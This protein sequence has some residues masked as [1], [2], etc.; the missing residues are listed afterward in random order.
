MTDTLAPTLPASPPSGPSAV[1]P[2]LR[3][4]EDL[5]HEAPLEVGELLGRGGMGEVRACVDARLGRELALKASTALDAPAQARF[6]REARIQGQ[7]E[8]PGMVPVHELGLDAKG[9]PYFTMKRV[10]GVTLA[11][12]L[13]RLAQGEAATVARFP[14][15]KLLAAVVSVAQTVDFAHTRGVMHRDVKPANVML[16]DFGEVYLLDWGLAKV[17]HQPVDSE[18]ITANGEVAAGA[19]LAG[20]VMG[21]PGYMAPEQARGQEATPASDVWALGSLLFEVLTQTPLIVARDAPSALRETLAFGGCSARARAPALDLAPELDALC[22]EATRLEAEARPTARQFSERLETV[23][24]GERDVELRQHLA[25][26]HA[27][28]AADAAQRAFDTGALEAR[29]LA[30]QEVGRALALEPEQ[31]LA[32]EVFLKLLA[33]PPA[34]SPPEVEAEE[35]ALRLGRVRRGLRSAVMGYGLMGCFLPF[36]LW[37]GVR[38][39]WP[40]GAMTVTWFLAFGAALLGSLQ[41][42]P[43]RWAQRGTVFFG[44][45]LISLN[46]FIAGPFL[47]VPGIIASNAMAAVLWVERGDR[48][49]VA[50]LSVLAVVLP[51]TLSLV[52]VLPPF[53]D[54]GADGFSVLPAMVHLAKGPTVALLVTGAVTTVLVA[55]IAMSG[56]RDDLDTANR[57]LALQRWNL[58]QF[59]TSRSKR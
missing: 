37:M 10:R 55:I 7:L 40:L 27:R 9:Q 58:E 56:A 59:R 35:R 22:L 13:R 43:S 39:A 24:A 41:A 45:V 28:A 32:H 52:G 38:D 33:H 54:F 34:E 29:R 42:A 11:E 8:H 1:N 3:P 4:L 14:R 15:R 50:L 31:A 46:C 44:A 5:V 25:L 53:Y 20:A 6:V 16:G 19:T 47:V 17:V 48:V 57:Q 12:V 21:T 23:L 30:L 36:L 51:L 49:P 2:S 18:V 26:E